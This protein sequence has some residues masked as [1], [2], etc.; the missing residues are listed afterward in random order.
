VDKEND[1]YDDD[2]KNSFQPRFTHQLF[3]NDHVQG[4]KSPKIMIYFTTGSL[5]AYIKVTYESKNKKAEDLRATLG[6]RMQDGW[7]ADETEFL[8]EVKKNVLWHPPGEKVY[9]YSLPDDENSNEKITYEL[10]K[11]TF[12]T[13]GMT[14]YHER[15]NFFFFGL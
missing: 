15:Y 13:E 1:L 9:E 6:S 12:D 3:P 5:A 2:L 11:G 10:Y 4:Y 8:K 7:T 14:D